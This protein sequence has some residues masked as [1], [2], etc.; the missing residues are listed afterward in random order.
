MAARRYALGAF[1]NM[2][3]Q[4]DLFRNTAADPFS[5]SELAR[6]K[7]WLRS[8]NVLVVA[9]RPGPEPGREE[10]GGA[11]PEVGRQRPKSAR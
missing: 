2:Q 10:C 1:L 3:H 8:V 7:K 6:S 11:R 5:I 4:N 9:F